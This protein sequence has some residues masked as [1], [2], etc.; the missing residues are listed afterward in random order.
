M[1]AYGPGTACL[2]SFESKCRAVSATRRKAFEE[3]TAALD[4]VTESPPQHAEGPLATTLARPD[5]RVEQNSSFG[6]SLA[7]ETASKRL[8]A[9]AQFSRILRGSV[10]LSAIRLPLSKCSLVGN[11]GDER[12]SA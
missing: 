3:A 12:T 1:S 8:L 10:T 9:S 4:V 5:P 7:S 6:I 11:G 2:R